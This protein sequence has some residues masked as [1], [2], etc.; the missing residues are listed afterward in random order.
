MHFSRLMAQRCVQRDR[1]QVDPFIESVL[2]LKHLDREVTELRRDREFRTAVERLLGPSDN[3]KPTLDYMQGLLAALDDDKL[4]PE[5][6]RAARATVKDIL[7]ENSEPAQDGNDSEE[8]EVRWDQEVDDIMQRWD[9]PIEQ[10][11]A[12]HTDSQISK[13]R[14]NIIGWLSSVGGV[15]KAY[16]LIQGVSDRRS[17]AY[18]PTNDL[19]SVLVQLCATD[20][21]GWHPVTNA[22]PRTVPLPYFLEWLEDRFGI[23][24]DRPPANLGFDS[25]EHMEAARANLGALLRRLQ[26]MGIFED[27]SDDFS[28]Q[29]LTP[30]FLQSAELRETGATTAAGS[31][32]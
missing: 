8:D 3:P 16:G 5:L 18:A 2:F 26:Q 27:Q 24:V 17:W 32:T 12:F 1:A 7:A 13:T 25:P 11:R 10:L 30:P 20:Y 29:V 19:L 4:S 15:G 21:K 31:A 28:V 9:S 6:R 23:I 14:P 22:T